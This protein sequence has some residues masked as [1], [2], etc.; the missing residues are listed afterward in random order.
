M[1]LELN[2]K[3]YVG[4]HWEEDFTALLSMYVHSF[5]CSRRRGLLGAL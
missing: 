3:A 1:Q 2:V 5:S 4:A